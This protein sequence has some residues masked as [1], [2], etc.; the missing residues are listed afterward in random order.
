MLTLLEEALFISKLRL[1]ES[2]LAEDRPMLLLYD[3]VEEAE[4]LGG[5][6]L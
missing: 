6:D 1:G 2:V 3:E 5:R 4:G